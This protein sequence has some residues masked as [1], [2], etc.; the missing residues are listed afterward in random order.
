MTT[1]NNCG[2]EPHCGVPMMKDF[3]GHKAT[4]GIEGQTEVC[5]QCNC[6][7]CKRPDWG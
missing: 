7:K 5:K 6:E 2:H 4:G 3:R 1:C